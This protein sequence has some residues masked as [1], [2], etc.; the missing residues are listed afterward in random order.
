MLG[1]RGKEADYRVAGKAHDVAAVRHH[2]LDDAPEDR[3]DAPR[4]DFDAGRPAPAQRLRQLREAAHVR[5]QN[6]TGMRLHPRLLLGTKL[7]Q[8]FNVQHDTSHP[9]MSAPHCCLR[10]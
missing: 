3:V 1:A 9:G 5:H 2:E 6:R 8:R 4:Q 10:L 7:T